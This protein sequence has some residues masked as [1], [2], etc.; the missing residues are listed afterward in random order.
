MAEEK[1]KVKIAYS[2]RPIESVDADGN[3][4]ITYEKYHPVTTGNAVVVGGK[5]LTNKLN[6]YYDKD[7]VDKLIDGAGKVH[8]VNG[9]QGT[10]ILGPDDVNAQPKITEENKLDAS[11][12]ENL[13]SSVHVGE[14]SPEG[15]YNIWVDTDE[16]EEGLDNS[17]QSNATVANDANFIYAQDE[18]GRSVR[19]AKS[20]LASIF[21]DYIKENADE[22]S[23]VTFGA[24]TLQDLQTTIG[25]NLY[26]ATTA[27]GMASVVARNIAIQKSSATANGVTFEVFR[28]G[29]IVML[30]LTGNSTNTITTYTDIHNLDY[31]GTG[32]FR[33]KLVADGVILGTR[34]NDSRSLCINYMAGGHTFSYASDGATIITYIDPS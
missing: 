7:K 3:R 31:C 14:D 15:D 10:V 28:Y 12:V 29:K 22:Q 23:K 1:K 33:L 27:S 18:D 26:G 24:S 6:E 9:Q 30:R 4:V 25:T 2:M 32:N 8:S 34:P 13:P 5:T 19:I 20:D 17:V 11:L 16:D 21:A